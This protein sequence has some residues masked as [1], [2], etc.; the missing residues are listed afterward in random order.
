MIII[1][2]HFWAMNYF[3]LNET[4]TYFSQCIIYTLN[5][6]FF[7]LSFFNKFI[8]FKNSSYAILKLM[9]YINII[10]VIIIK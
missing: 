10:K 7:L 4:F 5:G 3:I 2:I 8:G 9:V 1:I 6:I